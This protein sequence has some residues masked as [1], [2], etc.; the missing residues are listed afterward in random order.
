M[1]GLRECL[2]WESCGPRKI[3]ILTPIAITYGCVLPGP[4]G[5][6]DYKANV[7]NDYEYIGE[8]VAAASNTTSTKFLTRAAP[9]GPM[10]I[11]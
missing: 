4:N 8:T 5:I 7:V 9:V 3:K 1:N 10:L 11:Y 6:S 2:N